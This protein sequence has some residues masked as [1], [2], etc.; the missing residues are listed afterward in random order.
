VRRVNHLS[1]RSFS[2]GGSAACLGSLRSFLKRRKRLVEFNPRQFVFEEDRFLRRKRCRIVQ[3]RNREIDRVRIFRIFEKQMSSAT[4]G[5]RTNPIRVRNFARLAFSD[6]KVFARHRSPLH[7]RRTGASPA[8]DAVTIHQCQRPT[9]QHVSCPAANASTSQRHFLTFGTRRNAFHSAATQLLT[10][11][12]FRKFWQRLVKGDP[13]QLIFEP[14]RFLRR[15]RR[16]IIERRDRH[17]NDLGIFRVLEKQMRPA[18]R[19][20]RTNP[21]RMRNLARLTFCH[22]EIFARHRP[23][24]YVRRTGASPAID[25]VT[26]AQSKRPT[27]QHVSCPAANASTSELHKICLAQSNHESTRMN[28]NSCSHAAVRRL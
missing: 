26:I 23:P 18:T 27:L 19:G 13:R 11:A 28:T 16:G 1:R 21:V 3:R 17:I 7:V 5:K 2:R 6:D 14:D 8:I 4:C 12:A 22:G 9:L 25:A 15:K 24:G 20:E 10:L